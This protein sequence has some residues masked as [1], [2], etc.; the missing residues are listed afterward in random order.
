VSG[1]I[2]AWYFE[3]LKAGG[4]VNGVM[5]DYLQEIQNEDAA[6]FN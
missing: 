5:Q 2:I 4:T 3:H 1:L 6:P